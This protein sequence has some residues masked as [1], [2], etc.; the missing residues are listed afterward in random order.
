MAIVARLEVKSL[1]ARLPIGAR[2]VATLAK[3]V[4]MFAGE[5]ILRGRVIELL[6]VEAGGFPAGCGMALGAVAA[7]AA[8]VLVFVARTATWR[9]PH[10]C[11]VQVFAAKQCPLLRINMLG[12]VAG[13]AG[14]ADMLA[15]KRIAGFRVIES[16]ECRVPM[17]HLEI[18]A[19]MVGMTFHA[20][21]AR[22]GG[23]WKGGMQS[24]ILHELGRDFLVAFE[25]AESRCP[26]GDLVALCAVGVAAQALVCTSKRARRDLPMQHWRREDQSQTDQP[27]NEEV[28]P[29]RAG[30]TTISLRRRLM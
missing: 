24:P 11:V 14:H 17:N 26:G 12:S 22:R 10:P 9:E 30:A 25:A 5:R 15:V 2:C 21:L 7:K 1:V 29:W 6:C 8:L 19:I 18:R 16:L 28:P 3:D 20:G 4:T 27:S 13:A 23:S